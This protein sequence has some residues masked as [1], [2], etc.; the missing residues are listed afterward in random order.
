MGCVPSK[1]SLPNIYEVAN[2]DGDGNKICF[3]RLEVTETELILHQKHKAPTVWPLKSLR[4]YGADSELFSF[5]S[6]RRAPTGH[7]FYAFRCHRAEQLLS[8]LQ[9][10]FEENAPTPDPLEPTQPRNA[11]N[12]QQPLANGHTDSIHSSGP[13][14]PPPISPP[15]SG[16]EPI[17]SVPE[18]LT[19]GKGP[20][21][22]E[23]IPL[24][25]EEP[26]DDSNNNQPHSN[27]EFAVVQLPENNEISPPILA[28][29]TTYMNLGISRDQEHISHWMDHNGGTCNGEALDSNG[30]GSRDH[31]YQN[32]VPGY[33][34][35]PPKG[36]SII[37]PPVRGVHMPYVPKEST[38][39][40]DSRLLRGN[41]IEKCPIGP[42]IDEVSPLNSSLLDDVDD[43]STAPQVTY[44]L[45]D[46]NELS[47]ASSLT[48]TGA[49]PE[50]PHENTPAYSSID[51]DKMNALHQSKDALISDREGCRKTRHNSTIS[52]LHTPVE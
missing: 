18:T 20:S 31:L 28:S 26:E 25:P 15:A 8:Y 12:R 45:L 6:G 43:C 35:V 33:G 32:I 10:Q 49:H 5:E 44:A 29:S 40:N 30:E 19:N 48:P 2:V 41:Q 1:K 16:A 3:G 9:A 11:G 24:S 21:S 14:S 39:I 52:D 17:I 27:Y 22:T 4:R 47:P 51:F 50:S 37:H 23:N 7:G 36:I 38:S 46:L 42:S 34:N 13:V